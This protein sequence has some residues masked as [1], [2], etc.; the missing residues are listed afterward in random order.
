MVISCVVISGLMIMNYSKGLV[1]QFKFLLLLST[2]SVLVP[3]LLSVGAYIILGTKRNALHKASLASVVLLG[4]A[5]FIY[6]LWEIYGAGEQ[7]VYYGFLFLMAGVPFYI[8]LAYKK[9][10]AAE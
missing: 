1:E 4:L 3:Y 9:H 5:A 6:S 7:T 2:L 8:W 10:K